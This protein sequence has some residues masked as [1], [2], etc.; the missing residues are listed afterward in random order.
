MQVVEKGPK[1]SEVVCIGSSM[2]ASD[3]AHMRTWWRIIVGCLS[4][5]RVITME[6]TSIILSLAFRECTFITFGTKQL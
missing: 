3:V 1:N 2:W 5:Y 4:G 6:Y